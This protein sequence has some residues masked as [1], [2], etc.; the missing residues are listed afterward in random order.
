M[1]EYADRTVRGEL[2]KIVE[3]IVGLLL[4]IRTGF[5]NISDED[6]LTIRHNIRSLVPNQFRCEEEMVYEFIDQELKGRW[7]KKRERLCQD[8]PIF[9]FFDDDR[10]QR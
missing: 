4:E 9:R 5:K 2:I 10:S 7:F 8:S 1:S 6:L 3:G